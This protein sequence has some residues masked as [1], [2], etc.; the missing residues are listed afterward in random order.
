MYGFLP[1]GMFR[2]VN[3]LSTSFRFLGGVFRKTGEDGENIDNIFKK[4]TRGILSLPKA[5]KMKKG[6]F[7]IISKIKSGIAEARDIG[8]TSKFYNS[9]IKE[10]K[11]K[12]STIKDSRSYAS[13]DA[14]KREIEDIEEQI[15]ILEESRDSAIEMSKMGKFTNKF[16]KGLKAAPQFLAKSLVFF[17]KVM[18]YATLFLTIA[19]ILY[20]TVGKTI[21][22][23]LKTIY[24]AILQ[25][26]TIALGGIMLVWE[27][28][29]SIFKGFFGEG[30]SLN[31]VIDGVILIGLGILQFALGVVGTLLVALGGF[32]VEFVGIAFD[33]LKGFIS[34]AFKNTENFLKALP[35]ILLV[36][37]GLIAFIMGA[38]VWLALT[39]GIVLYKVAAFAVKKLA[40]IVPGFS[41][42]GTSSGGLAVVGE[43]GAELVS[44]PRG[45]RVHSNSQSKKMISNSSPVNNFNITINAK[46]TSD[47]E[48][49]RIA[50]KIGN[51]VNNSVN[52]ST[53]SAIMR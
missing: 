27:G 41:K 12:L 40:D 32:V 15:K 17:G 11:N 35:A 16:I 26:A 28:I 43:R 31:D 9:L 38:P 22:E 45:S 25:V 5:M 34:N 19:Y 51:M 23:T 3:K 18:L 1:P 50:Q 14:G 46:D 21:I 7:N 8:E 47:A 52:R 33:R 36:V 2:L 30:G 37:G 53:S 20:K 42:G 10:E 39:I 44:L 49:R 29:Q 24:P 4:M 13:S 6:D 48:L